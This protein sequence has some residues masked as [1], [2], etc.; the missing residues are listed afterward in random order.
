[1]RRMEMFHFCLMLI[2]Q[3]WIL[4]ALRDWT[5]LGLG[6]ISLAIGTVSGFFKEAADS[7]LGSGDLVET[8]GWK[9]LIPRDRRL[10]LRPN[11]PAP[12][13]L[14]QTTVLL[15]TDVLKR[16]DGFVALGSSLEAGRQRWIATA[17]DEKLSR[18]GDPQFPLA[19]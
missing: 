13:V 15:R 8:A 17:I 1:M 10:E 7:L 18:E 5:C 4:L 3:V 11:A 2:A 6:L 12:L 9:D 19:A 14:V 16:I